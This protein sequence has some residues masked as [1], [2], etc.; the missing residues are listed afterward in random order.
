M[1]V[2]LALVR[3]H[4]CLSQ[5]LVVSV[6]CRVRS[7]LFCFSGERRPIYTPSYLLRSFI[8]KKKI[9]E[10]LLGA[11][12]CFMFLGTIAEHPKVPSLVELLPRWGPGGGRQAVGDKDVGG[13]S[14]GG[15]TRGKGTSTVAL[16]G[17]RDIG[18]E[19]LAQ[20]LAGDQEVGHVEARRKFQHAGHWPLPTSPGGPSAF[21][22][23]RLGLELSSCPSVPTRLWASLFINKIGIA[24]VPC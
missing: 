21:P 2:L 16:G 8:K 7:H 15:R 24:V 23:H 17:I 12:I 18:K 3:R 20:R 1:Q 5:S 22:P 14:E 13:V 10:P 9:S 4:T 19:T 11:R 6:L